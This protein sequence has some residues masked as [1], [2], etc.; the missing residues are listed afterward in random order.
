MPPQQGDRLLDVVD[1]LLG[2]CPHGGA[3]SSS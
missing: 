1:Q 3:K 2:F